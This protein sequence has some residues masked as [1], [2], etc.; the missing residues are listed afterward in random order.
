MRWSR[1]LTLSLP[2]CAG[3]PAL[4]QAQAQAAQPSEFIHVITAT[5]R[6]DAIGEFEAFQKRIKAAAEKVAAPQR[7]TTFNVILGG[8]GRTYNVVLPFNKWSEVDGW[9]TVQQMLTK[10]FG[11]AEGMK[12]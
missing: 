3:W 5:V 10:A 4:G 8:P 12:M 6:T 2:L 7:W 9:M 1:A 11:A